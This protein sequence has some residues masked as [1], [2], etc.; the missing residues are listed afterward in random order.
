MVYWLAVAMVAVF[1]T[2]AADVL[3]VR[4][5]VPYGASTALFAVV[6]VVVFVAWWRVEGTLS[7]H[8]STSTR[9]EL[10]YWATVLATFALGTAAGDLL[11]TTA[12]HG[13]SSAPGVLFAGLIALPVLAWR[14]L[15]STPSW[16]SGPPTSSRARSGPRSRTG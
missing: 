4:F 14:F 9:R 10:F 5:G 6:L 1:G 16:R 15:G 2:M 13:L 12:G 7:I 11:A 8:R 3:H